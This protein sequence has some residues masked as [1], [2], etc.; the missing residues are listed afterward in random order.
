MRYSTNPRDFTHNRNFT[1][2]GDFTDMRYLGLYFLEDI[3]R[4][5]S[6][7]GILVRLPILNRHPLLKSFEFR[8]LD[9]IQV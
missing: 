6:G 8:V 3:D 7:S 4:F 9:D 1:D 2:I 5:R